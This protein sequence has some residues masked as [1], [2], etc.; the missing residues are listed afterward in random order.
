MNF[1]YQ[2][3][4]LSAHFIAHLTQF[5]IKIEI[6]VY[7]KSRLLKVFTLNNCN[8]SLHQSCDKYIEVVG[9]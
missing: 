5:D 3:S 1:F 9:I 7:K 2:K 8:I 4:L 6:Y